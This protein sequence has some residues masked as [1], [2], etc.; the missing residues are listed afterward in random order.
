M[1]DTTTTNYGLTK[2]EVGASEDTWGTKVNTDMD[3]V[4]AQMKVNA[5]AV[6][7][8]V[9]VANAALPKAGGTM[10]GVIAGF[11]STGIDDNA[12]STAITVGS[13]GNAGIGVVPASDWHPSYKA[14]ELASSVSLFGNDGAS[15]QTWLCNNMKYDTSTGT[16]YKQAGFASFYAQLQDGS[17][18]FKVAPSG[19]ADASGTFKNSLNIANNGDISFYEDT[20][21][22]AK[23]FWDASAESLGIGNSSPAHLLDVTGSSTTTIADFT[24]TDTSTGYGVYIKGGGSV[25]TRY[26]LRVDDAAGN[27]RFRVASSGLV[28]VGTSAPDAMVSVQRPSGTQGI[29]GGIS[30]KGQDG[31][32]QGGLGTD[33]VNDNYIQILAAQGVKFHTGNTNGTAN[34]RMRIDASGNVLV[35]KS[36]SNTSA[37]GSEFRSNGFAASTRSNDVVSSLNRLSSDGSILQFEKDGTTVGSIGTKSG[38]LF[39]GNGNANLLFAN[40]T[41]DVVPST[42]TGATN[43]NSIDLGAAGNRF[44]DL[45]LSGT[46]ST[47]KV[48]LND[49]GNSTIAGLQLG[50]QGIGLSVP[51]TDT[52]HF[53]TADQT[54][55]MISSAGKVGIGRT[56]TASYS[57]LEVGGADNTAL[58]NA[59]A[60][61]VFAGLGVQSGGLG[62]YVNNSNKMTINSSGAVMVGKTTTGFA[63]T[64]VSL[65]A[66]GEIDITASGGAPLFLRRNSSN[67]TIQAFYRD[68]TA[69]GSI[70]VTGSATAYNTSSDYRLKTDVQPMTGATATFMQ[71]KPCNFEWIADGTRVDGFLAHELGEVIPAAATGSKDG[72]MDEEYEVSPATGDVYT[73]AIEEVA[74][75]SQV[76]ETVEAG[77]YVNLAGETIVETEERGVTTD[78]VET[79]V[80]REDVDGLST[81]VEVEV[82]TQVPT[83]ETVITT[84]AVSEVIHSSDVEQPETLE[85]GQA[86][87]ETTAQVMATRSIPDMQGIDQAKVV[88][89]LVATIQEL[90]ARVEALEAV[91]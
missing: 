39:I 40:A 88:P 44:K 60:S 10:T 74:T 55:M 48:L 35:G 91:G 27:E 3:L 59:E 51:T 66:A 37:S 32:T 81:E 21:T 8:T 7:A 26:A 54:R 80:Q 5:D 42:G 38:K 20:G 24:N 64:G 73:A 63:T 16:T 67:G 75:E 69:V 49:N 29:A 41:D 9:V 1:A 11:E 52:M 90:I 2:P 62:L 85:D 71:L 28:G 50:N 31:T 56:P 65:I 15:P 87:R 23:F 47:G 22:T 72:M 84:P 6:A 83:M 25:G 33:G 68:A 61:G 77:S 45:H 89:L 46:M 19:A 70:S 78:L 86:W 17:H 34:E 18:Q 4:D 76:M 13:S 79:I 14:L 36:A 43:D 58:I 53:L 30:L 57:K 82:T 12:T